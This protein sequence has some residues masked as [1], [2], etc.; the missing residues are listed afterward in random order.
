MI[1]REFLLSED[2]EKYQ[3]LITSEI[4]SYAL[5]LLF[6]KETN[7]LHELRGVL[8]LARKIFSIPGQVSKDDAVRDMM[9]KNFHT[10]EM[11]FIKKHLT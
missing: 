3:A 9:Y 2:F 4:V 6:T 1:S 8:G 5:S 7:D 10:F 11:C